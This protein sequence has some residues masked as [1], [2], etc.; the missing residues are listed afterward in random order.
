M[1]SFTNAKSTSKYPLIFN[2]SPLLEKTY[3][4]LPL[5]TIKAKGWLLE[6]LKSQRSGA[7]GNMDN[8][9]P[10]VMGERNG[11][12]GG[13]GDQWERGPY[14]IDGLLPLAYI[15]DDEELKNKVKPWIEWILNSQQESGYFGPSVDYTSEPGLQRDNSADWWPRMVVLKILQQYYSATQDERVLSFMLNYFKYQLQTLPLKPLGNWTFWALYRMGDNLQAVHWLYNLTEEGFLL[16]LGELL[17]RQGHNFTH[18]FLHT[19]AMSTFN[20]IHCVNLAQGIKE[21]I[22]YFQQTHDSLYYFAVKKGLADIKK[23]NGQA[24]GMYGAD[25]GLHGNNPTQGVELCAIVEKMFSLEKMIEITGDL[26]FVEQLEKIAF[27]ALPTQITDD[28]MCK[29]YFQQANQVKITRHHRNFYEDA[30]HGGTDVVFGTLSGYPCCF[31]NMHQ[32]WPKFTQNLWYATSDGGLAALSY[33]PSE[34]T[35]CVGKGVKVTVTEDTFYPMDD[36]I[37]FTFNV[38]NKKK[39]RV[40]FPFHIRIPSWCKRAEI[41]IN[42]QTLSKDVRSGVEVIN[43]IWKTGD[44]LEL[45]FPM[46]VTI[47]DSW[48]E[49]SISI[50]RGPLVYALKIEEQWNK[51]DFKEQEKKNFGSYYWE[52]LPTTKWN[53]GIVNFDKKKANDIFEVKLLPHKLNS[54]YFW[55]SKNA[56]IEIYVKA[57]EIPSWKIYNDMAGP[58]P[59]SVGVGGVDP[60]KKIVLIPYGCTT[61]RVSQFPLIH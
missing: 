27:N 51:I 6:M 50:E 41:K 31:S 11:W 13:D 39:G 38:D 21:P 57:K 17:H 43:R 25:E 2:V 32:A 37:S 53:Y 40:E 19:D 29:Q 56:P 36:I 15:L 49:N 26:D 16:E 45:L 22:I 24:Q 35:A 12:L 18:M 20:S 42:G 58:L 55:N 23:Y 44:K 33:S 47:Q 5:G 7:T 3:T 60:I 59:Y 34:V 46:E 8:L 1:F 9:Y 4:E 52:V 10:S 48:Y 14:W 30:H 28:F 61:L 54:D